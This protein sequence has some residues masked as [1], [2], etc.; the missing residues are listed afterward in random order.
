[1]D[2]HERGGAFDALTEKR[3]KAELGGKVS[4][5]NSRFLRFVALALVAAPLVFADEPPS[6]AALGKLTGQSCFVPWTSDL[7][8]AAL[9]DADRRTEAA[10]LDCA[11][12][13]L[14]RVQKHFESKFVVSAFPTEETGP[15]PKPP[16][17]CNLRE[18]LGFAADFDLYGSLRTAFAESAEKRALGNEPTK[19]ATQAALERFATGVASQYRPAVKK[20]SAEAQDDLAFCLFLGRHRSWSQPRPRTLF[21]F[22]RG[23]EK[24]LT[25]ERSK[26][27]LDWLAVVREPEKHP[28]L[29]AA[30]LTCAG[31]RAPSAVS[32]FL[33][34]E[35]KLEKAHRDAVEAW[36]KNAG[37]AGLRVAAKDDRAYRI[38]V[39]EYACRHLPK[40]SRAESLRRV[41]EAQKLGVPPGQLPAPW[42]ALAW[43][44]PVNGR[45]V[46]DVPF[47]SLLRD[48]IA[49]EPE[50]R[51]TT[52]AIDRCPVVKRA[53]GEAFAERSRCWLE[54]AEPSPANALDEKPSPGVLGT[55]RAQDWLR[56]TR[57]VAKLADSRL[58]C[59][60]DGTADA[61]T[62]AAA[63]REL[64]AL[65]SRAL[66]RLEKALAGA[67][68]D[69]HEL[70][71]TTLEVRR[72]IQFAPYCL[73]PREH[74]PRFY[75]ARAATL[76]EETQKLLDDL[77]TEIFPQMG[78]LRRRSLLD[79]HFLW[80]A[81]GRWG[82]EPDTHW[83]SFDALFRW[84]GGTVAGDVA[85]IGW[86][87]TFGDPA[88][89]NA[90][91]K[92]LAPER[93]GG[94]YDA[95]VLDTIRKSSTPVIAAALV[96]EFLL[97]A[98]EG[99]Q[100]TAVR[101]NTPALV[102][103]ERTASAEL[104]ADLCARLRKGAVSA[105]DEAADLRRFVDG[106]RKLTPDGGPA[107]AVGERHFRLFL[108]FE[109]AARLR[110]LRELAGDGCYQ[111]R[112]AYRD[113][114]LA[115]ALLDPP[116]AAANVDERQRWLDGFE[117]HR[118]ACAIAED[119]DGRVKQAKEAGKKLEERLHKAVH[120]DVANG[121]SLDATLLAAS[122]E[123]LRGIQ[124]G[125]K[126]LPPGFG[127]PS[128]VAPRPSAPVTELTL[129][130]PPVQGVRRFAIERLPRGEVG[131]D[132][133]KGAGAHFAAVFAALDPK[134]YEGKPAEEVRR[135]LAELLN[136]AWETSFATAFIRENLYEVASVDEKA[137]AKAIAE[138]FVAD[139]VKNHG[140]ASDLT[141]CKHLREGYERLGNEALRADPDAKALYDRWEA[142][143]VLQLAL[144]R[145][146][147]KNPEIPTPKQVLLGLSVLRDEL[148]IVAARLKAKLPGS[149]LDPQ[150]V[151]TLE[152]RVLRNAGATEKNILSYL[153]RSGQSFAYDHIP[154]AKREEHRTFAWKMLTQTI[155]EEMK[156]V[157]FGAGRSVKAIALVDRS[158]VFVKDAQVLALAAYLETIANARFAAERRI[159][160]I[161][162]E[163]QHEERYPEEPF[164]VGVAMIHR[165]A[166][167]LVRKL[168]DRARKG[169]LLEADVAA[170]ARVFRDEVSRLHEFI[171]SRCYEATTPYTPALRERAIVFV[172]LR[173][174]GVDEIVAKRFVAVDAPAV[175]QRHPELLRLHERTQELKAAAAAVR[176][177]VHAGRMGTLPASAEALLRCLDEE[178]V[179]TR[180]ELARLKTMADGGSLPASPTMALSRSYE[181]AANELE[182]ALVRHIARE[183][184]LPSIL[185]Y[186]HLSRVN[187]RF[188]DIVTLNAKRF[189]YVLE[190]F[191]L[192]VLGR[193]SHAG[194][195]VFDYMRANGCEGYEAMKDYKATLTSKADSFRADAVNAIRLRRSEVVEDAEAKAR[196]P[197]WVCWAAKVCAPLGGQNVVDRQ[198]ECRENKEAYDAVRRYLEYPNIEP[199][200][201]DTDPHAKRV[202][203]VFVDALYGD[204]LANGGVAARLFKVSVEEPEVFRKV[205]S[206]LLR[207]P[208]QHGIRQV[209]AEVAMP[210]H[211]RMT[212]QLARNGKSMVGYDTVPV[213]IAEL[214]EFEDL[215]TRVPADWYTREWARGKAG[216]AAPEGSQFHHYLAAMRDAVAAYQRQADP[217]Q[218]PALGAPSDRRIDEAA[219][220]VAHRRFVEETVRRLV[221]TF[222]GQGR[223]DRERLQALELPFDDLTRTFDHS[224]AVGGDELSLAL[225][226]TFFLAERVLL[227]AAYRPTPSGDVCLHPALFPVLP[228]NASLKA[229]PRFICRNANQFDAVDHVK[230]REL[231]AAL[232]VLVR[233]I[234]QELERRGAQR[235]GRRAMFDAY[236]RGSLGYDAELHRWETAARR[237]EPG[238]T[239][240]SKLGV[241]MVD[242]AWKDHARG[243]LTTDV[244]F[245][246]VAPVTENGRTPSYRR[247]DFSERTLLARPKGPAWV[248]GAVPAAPIPPDPDDDLAGLHQFARAL[249]A[250][251]AKEL[252]KHKNS[253]AIHLLNSIY[254]VEAANYE[255]DWWIG[256]QLGMNRT[257]RSRSNRDQSNPKFVEEA[258]GH[259]RR[260]RAKQLKL[261]ERLIGVETYRGVPPGAAEMW[262][263]LPP[264]LR[265]ALGRYGKLQ[266][267][268]TADPNLRMLPQS[269]LRAARDVLFAPWP[270][271]VVEFFRNAPS[272]D[273]QDVSGN[274]WPGFAADLAALLDRKL[275]R[276]ASALGK[277]R[278]LVAEKVANLHLLNLEP[279]A[280]REKLRDEAVALLRTF[281]ADTAV[282]KAA[283]AISWESWGR[284]PTDPHVRALKIL[285]SQ[286]AAKERDRLA[287]RSLADLSA[288]DLGKQALLVLIHTVE[289][290]GNGTAGDSAL[291]LE[292]ARGGLDRFSPVASAVYAE[293]AAGNPETRGLGKS[294]LAHLVITLDK[295]EED[296]PAPAG[297]PGMPPTRLPVM[298][299]GLGRVEL[300]T[301]EGED[302]ERFRELEAL[303]SRGGGRDAF[304][305][306]ELLYRRLQFEPSISVSKL[307]EEFDPAGSVDAARAARLAGGRVDAADRILDKLARG[308][309]LPADLDRQVTDRA[310]DRW[311][312]ESADK[313]FRS[314]VDIPPSELAR[315]REAVLVD[316][317]RRAAERLLY[318]RFEKAFPR[319]LKDKDALARLRTAVTR[320]LAVVADRNGTAADLGTLPAELVGP[321]G[322]FPT[323]KD[324]EPFRSRLRE[325][326]LPVARVATATRPVPTDDRDRV[327]D[328]YLRNWLLGAFG[329]WWADRHA[330]ALENDRGVAEL[331]RKA[332]GAAVVVGFGPNPIGALAAVASVETFVPPD[333]SKSRLVDLV[334]DCRER[335]AAAYRAAGLAMVDPAKLA[336]VRESQKALYEHGEQLRALQTEVRTAKHEALLFAQKA[337]GLEERLRVSRRFEAEGQTDH[338]FY[339]DKTQA[340]RA[341]AM[342][343]ELRQKLAAAKTKLRAAEDR[344]TA[345]VSGAADAI[346]GAAK[347]IELAASTMS[348]QSQTGAELA[349]RAF[350]AC[351]DAHVARKR[352]ALE[353]LDVDTTLRDQTTAHERARALA[354]V[355]LLRRLRAAARRH[356]E[357]GGK[358]DAPPAEVRSWLE[359]DGAA[360]G[361]PG[362]GKDFVLALWNEEARRF[363]DFEA[364]YAAAVAKLAP[365]GIS[366][367][368]LE[369]NPPDLSELKVPKDATLTEQTLRELFR[370]A[371]RFREGRF[372]GM[373]YPEAG[374]DKHALADLA[375]EQARTVILAQW[376]DAGRPALVAMH[377]GQ[378]VRR[379]PKTC[380]ADE[381]QCTYEPSVAVGFQPDAARSSYTL[382]FTDAPSE[383]AKGQSALAK[384]Q[385]VL[386]NHELFVDL[387]SSAQHWIDVFGHAPK[388]KGEI[389]KSVG[390]L[391]AAIELF[392]K[393][394]G[395]A[396]VHEGKETSG[397]TLACHLRAEREGG[398]RA[399]IDETLKNIEHDIFWRNVSGTIF[400]ATLVLTIATAGAATPVAVAVHSGLHAALVVN[401]LTQTQSIL[402]TLAYGS[403]RNLGTKFHDKNANWTDQG[404]AN[405][406]STALFFL[407][408]STSALVARAAAGAAEVA[409]AARNAGVS[410]AEARVALA[411]V[412]AAQARGLAVEGTEAARVVM[413]VGR[414]GTLAE[415]MAALESGLSFYQ[416]RLLRLVHAAGP[417]PGM[418]IN[419]GFAVG[420]H[421]AADVGIAIYEGRKVDANFVYRAIGKH[422]AAEASTALFLGG[423]D[424]F[425]ADRIG[426][427]L[428]RVAGA[429]PWFTWSVQAV[430]AGGVNVTISLTGKRIGDWLSDVEYARMFDK[431][432]ATPGDDPG[433]R[434]RRDGELVG[435]VETVEKAKKAQ[436]DAEAREWLHR[437]VIDVGIFGRRAATGSFRAQAGLRAAAAIRAG[438]P[439]DVVL[440]RFAEESRPG[441]EERLDNPLSFF[442]MGRGVHGPLPTRFHEAPGGADV[443]VALSEAAAGSGK[444]SAAAKKVLGE[445]LD[446]L[447]SALRG[448]GFSDVNRREVERMVRRFA[449][450]RQLSEQPLLVGVEP[451]SPGDPVRYH[452]SLTTFAT[453]VR[454]ELRREEARAAR[455]ARLATADLGTAAAALK[456]ERDAWFRLLAVDARTA[457]DFPADLL[458]LPN[459]KEVRARAIDALAAA[460]D[461][462]PALLRAFLDRVAPVGGPLPAEATLA[463]F[464]AELRRAAPTD[465]RTPRRWMAERKVGP[466]DY[467]RLFGTSDAVRAIVLDE[468]VEKER[469]GRKRIPNE[470]RFTRWFEA[471]WSRYA[472]RHLD[473]DGWVAL[474]RSA[475]AP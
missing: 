346:G 188:Q 290:L 403:D 155:E 152:E 117:K 58:L 3:R 146:L 321:N 267:A 238:A 463:P 415:S 18:A 25:E 174:L 417:I 303:L 65:D 315:S 167:R 35:R 363:A 235:D 132:W 163:F 198:K 196:L 39:Q 161:R 55:R 82:V 324:F 284:L 384:A 336:V 270:G 112:P 192:D 48:G 414:G 147:Q 151:A 4:I 429:R 375:F 426:R 433:I 277:V 261:Q 264:F 93:D 360:V 422:A 441:F 260:E 229:D 333:P 156:P 113:S 412:Q 8:S 304:E 300:C 17:P 226:R 386:E 289:E 443:L 356:V 425:M 159:A 232:G 374:W 208:E 40:D 421:T 153:E 395:L 83:L 437:L 157:D 279:V 366:R 445:E 29:G 407:G 253:A 72:K 125:L 184:K 380:T 404:K 420:G 379:I 12:S 105:K 110:L 460:H 140:V 54:D 250:R 100:A 400:V 392:D 19:E 257:G 107:P 61:V 164:P 20:L 468:V 211:L 335:E 298:W 119:I 259:L 148:K 22:E 206:M 177:L 294:A 162:A 118:I 190:G 455:T 449:A 383:I 228:N 419:Y 158:P 60:E 135:T 41:T 359:A 128:V 297:T 194:D 103:S 381:T 338:P 176:A 63:L 115:S 127:L 149:R 144:Q 288:E 182:D 181:L 376:A 459:R 440:K 450:D 439:A 30:S 313:E 469:A 291:S 446:S 334:A 145:W 220:V 255:G 342:L 447:V 431:L 202:R 434:A 201:P 467:A 129:A 193:H 70:V 453:W 11:D 187:L 249:D 438:E 372:V 170:F 21:A 246:L 64:V 348:V 452:G 217:S 358:A 370:A 353:A 280:A 462:D 286:E 471:N 361:L 244:D 26:G 85:T 47:A 389:D 331:R 409:L 397:S 411:E 141:A 401:A 388:A 427:F 16:V 428:T 98:L 466:G 312:A 178:R 57:L 451:A 328:E 368:A 474:Y 28:D 46:V 343:G 89:R 218:L 219:L 179:A 254:G 239:V 377:R 123:D 418:T 150:E 1:M 59:N 95:T 247:P 205:A 27:P 350:L 108:S 136:P 71:P 423:G 87:R 390:D 231:E 245:E 248:T 473:V 436:H 67:D 116:S 475:G 378:L 301:W 203:E 138:K 80:H 173:R 296:R 432:L 106:L 405:L 454:R 84:L 402:N 295:H 273:R 240:P 139:V 168:E 354:T 306:R 50:D 311:V 96:R 183:L 154:E 10:A 329:A 367:V 52:A 340:P 227:R 408:G 351:V 23:I 233:K 37:V 86:D 124:A 406:I 49:V 256:T 191:P 444:E 66:E 214:R 448:E 258:R 142:N 266:E 131:D 387:R 73:L 104:R 309:R 268:A 200:V 225:A 326:L 299:S 327:N 391:N 396:F 75:V 51:A 81:N 347:A 126:Q 281:Y 160:R 122:L 424:R 212:Y 302:L 365:Y 393:L 204:R 120:L 43:I 36:R 44:A 355:T 223:C 45:S 344:F 195:A 216:V 102:A 14:S 209:A 137:A 323:A 382:S 271:R 399:E 111:R 339:L 189:P 470:A 345:L 165:N 465:P 7:R 276:D 130:T 109:S 199:V 134:V 357:A 287:G 88:R 24:L 172:L 251:D 221:R 99:A 318:E 215:M 92:S 413:A 133:A 307:V 38:A 319:T 263:Q 171:R 236:A 77:E 369:R 207:L 79:L 283:R 15:A 458:V 114:L 166:D 32:A 269:E 385:K 34:R 285:L 320:L 224:D 121:A 464:V 305:R 230:L 308:E 394:D 241:R 274:F 317:R 310:K 186:P 53:L 90:L 341:Q 330:P 13:V 456:Q 252:W 461:L 78:S 213:P 101:K 262:R 322:M 416:G 282:V 91:R 97:D 210:L 6:G 175:V 42:V 33:Y 293:V 185:A 56:K 371:S 314:A 373:A 337:F 5:E 169:E 278:A 430:G 442:D 472:G 243:R 234:D 76:P 325:L 398:F 410:L 2:L 237:E 180:K 31:A 352:A 9:S 94:G 197:K 242:A 265:S 292:N 143:G 362:V 62:V 68:P 332:A 364:G 349:D 275:P 457:D 435:L 74:D 272:P 222:D 316:F 69:T